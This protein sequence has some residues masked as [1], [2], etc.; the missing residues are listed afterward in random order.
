ME[1]QGVTCPDQCFQVQRSA[2]ATA[3]RTTTAG[4]NSIWTE[5]CDKMKTMGSESLEANASITATGTDAK[6]RQTEATSATTSQQTATK[7]RAED[8]FDSLAPTRQMSKSCDTE[9]STQLSTVV[10]VSKQSIVATPNPMM[11][12]LQ[13]MM[14]IAVGMIQGEAPKNPMMG[15]IFNVGS[16][17]QLALGFNEAVTMCGSTSRGIQQKPADEIG[18]FL[19]LL[20]TKLTQTGHHYHRF[21]KHRQQQIIELCRLHALDQSTDTNDAYVLPE[22]VF[23]NVLQHYIEDNKAKSI[24]AD[25]AHATLAIKAA[26]NPANTD[27]AAKFMTLMQNNMCFMRFMGESDLKYSVGAVLACIEKV[28]PISVLASPLV[29]TQKEGMDCYQHMRTKLTTAVGAVKGTVAE[30]QRLR[31]LLDQLH[32]MFKANH[33]MVHTGCFEIQRFRRCVGNEFIQDALCT[34]KVAGKRSVHVLLSDGRRVKSLEDIPSVKSD[35]RSKIEAHMCKGTARSS[36][37]T[38][39]PLVLGNVR[40]LS[41]TQSTPAAA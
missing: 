23:Q 5:I 21:A 27:L 40:A 36:K 12:N 30:K 25:E 15:A 14:N 17:V 13:S 1:I 9:H 19:Q 34:Y 41:A 31:T 7:S 2:T 16:V 24:L 18:D 6:S 26:G 20:V 4:T 38:Q 10:P 8:R 3:T 35:D 39:K 32:G 33:Q 37:V 28:I 22:K 29:M 11:P